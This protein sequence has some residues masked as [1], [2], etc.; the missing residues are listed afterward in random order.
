VVALAAAGAW[1]CA[2]DSMTNR[3]ATGFNAF[4]NKIEVE[5]NPLQIG[6]YQMSEMIK[7]NRMDENYI[8]FMDQTSRVYYGTISQA[9]YAQSINA[10]FLGGSTNI[11]IDCILSKLPQNQR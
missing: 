5:C 8:Y 7:Y 11:A 10:F 4:L 6:N 2:P 3:Q 1:G 9:A